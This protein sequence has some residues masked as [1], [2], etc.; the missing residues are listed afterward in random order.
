[1]RAH[2]RYLLFRA[3]GWRLTVLNAVV[4][5][6]I[7]LAMTSLL[8]VIEVA[9]T[10]AEMNGLLTRT[11]KQE[12]GEDLVQIVRSGHPVIDPPRPFS[13]APRQAFFLLLDVRGHIYEGAS[14]RIPGLPDLASLHAVL[15]TGVPD[16]RDVTIQGFHL[17]LSTVPIRDRNGASI[18]AIQAYVSLQG[19]D[20][21]LERL[22]LVL[23]VGSA[24]GIGLSVLAARFLANHALVPIWQAFEQQEQFVAD[25]SHEL[26]AP[27]A[28][29]QADVEVLKR[30]LG[31]LP[32]SWALTG[33]SKST[34]GREDSDAFLSLSRDD[35]EIVD[36]MAAEIGHMNTL[37]ADLLTLARYDAGVHS[38]PREIVHLSELLALLAERMR[39]QVTQAHLTLHLLLPDDPHGLVIAGDPIALRQLFVILLTNAMSYTPAGGHIWLQGHT[40]SG[41][42]IQVSVRDTGSGIAVSDLPHLFT[43]F[44]RADKARSRH[45]ATTAE[46]APVG[47]GLGLAI[48]HS[49]V[50]QHGGSITVSSPGEG[51]GSTFTV[52][53]KRV[54]TNSP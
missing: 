13:P 18:G 32:A 1:M 51:Q 50:E 39:V 6:T 54:Q 20:S 45:G 22:V 14:Y 2:A 34:E 25:A 10:D 38:R 8:Y 47:V 17:R 53:L 48:A 9:T 12:R 30:A 7:L 40:G 16:M 4:L 31:L 5:C 33:A 24:L 36:E 3:I 52:F 43:R 21:E 15:S 28:L 44:Y 11:V 35:V 46:H 29:L 42:Q 37:I 23:L 19:R 41:S 27:L 49:I 26:R